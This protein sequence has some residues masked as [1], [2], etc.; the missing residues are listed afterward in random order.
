MAKTAPAEKGE[1]MAAWTE[2]E[3]DKIGNTEELEI[4]PRRS[5]GRLRKP[6]T[7]WAVRVGDDLYVRSFNGRSG[8]WYRAVQA[9]HEGR[10]WAGGVEKEVTFVAVSDAGLN[11]RVDEAYRAKYRRY[12]QYAEPMVR[13]EARAT[14]I[15]LAPR[16]TETSA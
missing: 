14:T 12:P 9:R 11:D 10:I 4:A 2:A 6:T 13:P 15:K 8:V 16:A 7:I 1:L 5:D 3:L